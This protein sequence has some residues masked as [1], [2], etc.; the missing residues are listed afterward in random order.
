M[1][2]RLLPLQ[3]ARPRPWANGGGTTRELLAWPTASG[4]PWQVRVSVATID[5]DGPFSLLPGVRRWFAVLSGSGV[6]LT[7]PER[8]CRLAPGDDPV[9]FD[10]ADAPDCRLTGGA[11]QDLNLMVREGE[12]AMRAVRAGQEQRLH[13]A[14]C[15]LYAVLAGTLKSGPERLAVDAQTL[16]WNDAPRAQEIWS[17]DPAPGAA[18]PVGFW[19]EFAS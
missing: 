19:L 14:Q 7:W 11:T 10:G 15:G 9:E 17:F 16:V 8:E 1:A 4:T 3:D 12:A 5:R 2:I 13:A 6:I 18:A